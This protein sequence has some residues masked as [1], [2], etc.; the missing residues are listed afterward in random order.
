MSKRPGRW[1]VF[2]LLTLAAVLHQDVWNWRELTWV[3]ALPAG[4][5]YHLAYCLF[6]SA[7]MALLLR[8]EH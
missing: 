8:L 7:L 1:L 3:A 4:F 6:V 2:L 5:A